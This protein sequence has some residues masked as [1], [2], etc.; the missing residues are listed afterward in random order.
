METVI[1]IALTPDANAKLTPLELLE[2][3]SDASPDWHYLEEE[4][5]HYAEA[6]GA[7]GCV[8]RYRHA[9]DSTYVDFAFASV[10][11]SALND[12]ELVILDAPNP[13]LELTLEQ[14]NAVVDDFLRDVRDYL[15]ARPG[16]ATLRVEKDSVNKDALNKDALK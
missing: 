9:S 14:R 6:K 5:A 15:N 4:S 7:P 3:F 11:P 10:N 1:H 13:D 2:D 16:H 8:L 12:V